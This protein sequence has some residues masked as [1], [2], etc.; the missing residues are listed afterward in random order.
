MGS[1]N[2][3]DGYKYDGTEIEGLYNVECV[4]DKLTFT[5]KSSSDN[6]TDNSKGDTTNNP[7]DNTPDEKP[8]TPESSTT[9]TVVDVSDGSTSI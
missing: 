7:S 1:D 9:N 6:T 4:A 3:P 5:A 2:L 8:S